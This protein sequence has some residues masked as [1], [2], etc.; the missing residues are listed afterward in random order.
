MSD[1]MGPLPYAEIEARLV[2]LSTALAFPAT[3]D[4][5]S[6]VGSR[7]RAAAS[8]AGGTVAEVRE[9]A[10]RGRA[11]NGSSMDGPARQMPARGRVVPF[12]GSVRRSLLL[13]AALALLIVGGVFAVRFGLELLSIEFGPVPTLGPPSPSA[14][15]HGAVGEGLALGLPVGVEEA[16]AE[17]AF[18]VLVPAALGQPDAVYQGGVPLRGQVA[19]VYAPRADLPASP[20]LGGAGLLLTQNRGEPDRG[21]ANKLADNNL[22]TVESVVVDGA[23]GLWITGQPHMFWYL[24]PDGTA[25]EDS[26]RLVGD[27]LAW[28]RDGVLYRIE[29]E[30]SLERALEIAKSMR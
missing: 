20:L 8:G 17:A 22:A 7:L 9:R 1:R 15:A 27:T 29:G 18:D 19:L 26:R 3:P 24:S 4:L 28:E 30:I 14:R 5:A 11:A 6:A 25:I 21:L 2:D 10:E 23:P 12:R 16:T 13:A